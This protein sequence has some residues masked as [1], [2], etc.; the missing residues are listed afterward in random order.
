MSEQFVIQGVL[1][2]DVDPGTLGKVAST[3]GNEAKSIARNLKPA[4]GAVEALAKDARRSFSSLDKDLEIFGRSAK[5]QLKGIQ[6]LGLDP[7][8]LATAQEQLRK[9]LV[10]QDEFQKEFREG[11]RDPRALQGLTR[12]FETIRTAFSKEVGQAQ[13]LIRD[14]SARNL[15]SLAESERRATVA[16]N[17][18]KQA[19]A[20]RDLAQTKAALQQRVA[21]T[22]VALDTI[23]RLEKGF[24]AVIAG[25]A[26]TAVG[27]V[28]K[29]YDGLVGSLRRTFSERRTIVEGGLRNETRL[30]T[31]ASAVQQRAQ[32]GFL[33]IGVRQAAFVGGGLGLVTALQK[34]FT[35]GA[36][37]SQGL[38]VLQ[39]QLELTDEE[40]KNVRKT[41]ID[42]GNDIT[43][44]GV[45][46]LDAAT[47]INLLS[48]QF[49][50]LG[51][52][53]ITASTAA[54]QGTLRLQIATKAT[55]EEAA[56]LVG[57]AVN[58]FGIAA[59]EATAVADQISQA[60]A[61]SA[62]INVT[63]FADA[64]TQASTVFSQF[65]TPAEGATESLVDFNTA[66]AA[67][68]KGGL[69]G[70]D[71]GTSLRS[72]FIQANRGTDDSVQAL[73][74]LSFRAGVT[75][76]AFFD[77]SGK[78]RPFTETL[79]ILRTGLRGLSDEQKANTL[80]TV[81]GTDAIRAANILLGQNAFEY[82]ALRDQIAAS[83]GAA[84]RFA[85]AQSSGLRRAFDAIKSS[86]E[87]LQ[88]QIFGFAEKFLAP[89]ALGFA[90]FIGNLVSGS[91][92]FETVRRGL[93]GVA[94]GLGAVIAAKLGVEILGLLAKTLPLLL[95]PFGALSVLAAGLGAAFLI[96]SKGA[97]SFH[98]AI[99]GTLETLRNFRDTALDVFQ[100]RV[101]PVLQQFARFAARQIEPVTDRIKA[102]GRS[103][104]DFLA[105]AI[106]VLQ[107]FARQFAIA[108]DFLR[109]GD[110]ASALGTLRFIGADLVDLIVAPLKRLGAAALGAIREGL[111]HIDLGA[112]LRG[113]I[114]PVG[115]AGIGAG[116]GAIIGGPLGA[117][118]GG[119]VALGVRAALPRIRDAIGSI[120]FLALFG[121]AL[122]GV[123]KAGQKIAEVLF[124]RR[125]LTAAAGVV[126][127]AIALAEQF[128]QGVV[129]G[130][131]NRLP[132]IA[133]VAQL[134]IT[135]L[136]KGLINAPP[137][138]QAIA[139][140][141]ILFRSNLIRLF[142]T[143][144][145][146]EQAAEEVSQSFAQQL[147]QKLAA[148]AAPVVAA[149][150]KIGQG[151]G[152]GLT[153]GISA[154][155]SGSAIGSA[156]SGLE[157][158]LGIAGLAGSA[159]T[160]FTGA[161][162]LSGGNV[163]IGASAAAA[164]VAVG[165][166]TAALSANAKNAQAAKDRMLEFSSALEEAA[167]TGSSAASAIRD[168]IVGNFKD[169]G[170][171]AL[172]GFQVLGTSLDD[173]LAS[174][175]AG[176]SGDFITKLK[177][178][179]KDLTDQQTAFFNTGQIAKG[180]DL[181]NQID[182]A[183]KALKFFEQQLKAADDAGALNS[184]RG[185]V[186]GVATDVRGGGE[187]FKTL[188]GFA[189]RAA[190]AVREA[191]AARAEERNK[192]AIDRL[193]SA[194]DRAKT[195]ADKARES[196]RQ[197]ITG[198]SQTP[199][200]AAN[201][202]VVDI[203][204]VAASV[205]EAV[206]TGVN[207]AFG[208]AQ[209]AQGIAPFTE[210]LNTIVQSAIS[211][212][213]EHGLTPSQVQSNID[214]AF[215][216]VTA[217]IGQLGLAPEAALPLIAEI[218]RIQNDPNI[219]SLS[220]QIQTDEA[221]VKLA[222][223]Q[224]QVR[225]TFG[226]SAQ[227]VQSAFAQTSSATT[228]AAA[229]SANSAV[230]TAQGILAANPSIVTVKPDVP[231][232]AAAGAQAGGAAAAGATAQTGLFSAIGSSMAATLAASL[233]GGTATGGGVAAGSQAA[234]GASSQIGLFSGIGSSMV[235]RLSAGLTSGGAS[236]AGAEAGAQ[237][238]AGARK[239]V[240]L[241]TSIGQQMAAGLTGGIRSAAGNVAAAAANMVT[242]AVTAAKS[243]ALISSPSRV[244]FGIGE[245]IVAGLVE[246][247]QD[248]TVDAASVASDL[249]DAVA[250]SFTTQAQRSFEI[251]TNTLGDLLSAVFDEAD[252]NRAAVSASNNLTTAFNGIR[253]AVQSNA[254]SL[255]R[256]AATPPGERSALDQ[257]LASDQFTSLSSASTFGAAN[258]E[259]I[260]SAAEAV[261]TFAVSLLR[262]G[263]SVSSVV[264]QVRA[265]RQQLIFLAGSLGL[266]TDGTIDLLTQ[267][268][269]GDDR[270]NQ[271]VADAQRAQAI[272][273]DIS[274]P[275]QTPIGTPATTQPVQQF[276][277]NHF[278]T[279]FG[280]PEAVSLA[281][282]NRLARLVRT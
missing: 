56:R 113:L 38:R 81:F 139:A 6:N 36:D 246:G 154:A 272:L 77:L 184:L 23:G 230:S 11:F 102:L 212:G 183:R 256:A 83:T 269:L 176:T 17:V 82:Q 243:R 79:N 211:D 167:R 60:L 162:A 64:F 32:Q 161:T 132:D 221:Q 218:Q 119:A 107:R 270:L 268:G 208:S 73:K 124:D 260:A 12:Q 255:L 16:S 266:A 209:L 224:V 169:L 58:V 217:A 122:E 261:Q 85:A 199:Q 196:L 235:A 121:R 248:S 251:S 171:D 213:V 76:T 150:K 1:Q 159:A 147:G 117:A 88:I 138:V 129:T 48:K 3:L 42:L 141:V 219:N 30:F 93:L 247:I 104:L 2:L 179:I 21:A 94:A 89:L 182:D 155:L 174:L 114:T 271:F 33:G 15:V 24:G 149:A 222:D 142:T 238:A 137:I 263:Q 175:E 118:I 59:T 166:L 134:I 8:L 92:V 68:A 190:T 214:A 128:V 200:A 216:Q 197:L 61:K 54:A 9:L 145:V 116:I 105:P 194:A 189:Q 25:T 229:D 29:V 120:D 10:L 193:K 198:Q 98:D 126:A 52:A 275:T 262:Q 273:N 106:P 240:G 152:L 239:S 26:R 280:D 278:E 7:N 192:E 265:Y 87:T 4:T 51:P 146:G 43:L 185:A 215:S 191:I 253:S 67:L 62:G 13:T 245:D 74:E 203:P 53:A 19:S 18:S 40:M 69:I 39:A 95:T 267:L 156:T 201:Q 70:S 66:I 109:Q 232:S 163:A 110:F 207:T 153:T 151:I 157:S 99:Q 173:F 143:S 97:G 71:A 168:T 112:I 84:E 236:S 195:A 5:A 237:A 22:R 210:D 80:Q 135:T 28:S 170:K 254:E 158:G 206:Q 31:Q 127:A 250:Q 111:S 148:K 202:T 160:A 172:E 228:A 258:R 108:F 231:G 72:F 188:I 227:E 101:L 103:I 204:G 100:R 277:E 46:A 75:G 14:Q 264:E 136:A 178:Q 86:I 223:F 35:L 90:D 249:A 282:A 276:F 140:L 181:R 257:I 244:F 45:S 165:A 242:A 220:L 96:G 20:Q 49:A 281:V 187:A 65:V 252:I 78:A 91:G 41:S 123:R 133:H 125:T 37:F 234:G 164:T 241:F 27:A 50:N 130:I 279:P 233:G 226:A 115:V 259:A 55:A 57:S 34:T 131:I 186:K 274:A 144:R 47:A 180:N 225:E 44:P 177:D 63:Q 205:Q